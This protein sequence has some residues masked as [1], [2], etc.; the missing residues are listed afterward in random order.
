[1][2]MISAAMII[3]GKRGA[4]EESFIPDFASHEGVVGPE[5]ASGA[6]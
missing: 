3:S 1:M 4:A 6:E 2:P 5:L